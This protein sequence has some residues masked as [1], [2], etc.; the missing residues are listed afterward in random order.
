MA[1]RRMLAGY[2]L[3]PLRPR[4]NTRLNRPGGTR[5]ASEKSNPAVTRAQYFALCFGL[6]T[7]PRAYLTPS[8]P[9]ACDSVVVAST[10]DAS[11]VYVH[12]P[13]EWMSNTSDIGFWNAV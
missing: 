12:P 4:H 13:G 8:P 10:V 9:G 11:A 7:G 2:A 3:P 5:S 1:T 6:T